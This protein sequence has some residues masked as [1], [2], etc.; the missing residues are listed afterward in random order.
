[1]SHKGDVVFKLEHI[2]SF[3]LNTP[4]L[5]LLH[6]LQNI[7]AANAKDFFTNSLLGNLKF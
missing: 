4:W 7:P 6:D 2:Q 3:D 1:M 5:S